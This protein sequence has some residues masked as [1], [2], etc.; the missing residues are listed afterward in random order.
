MRLAGEKHC[1]PYSVQ[2]QDSRGG[3]YMV[4]KENGIASKAAVFRV[5]CP[6]KRKRNPFL[7]TQAAK[8]N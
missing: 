5:L 6:F 4:F 1:T 7:H 2:Q 3:I 8:I